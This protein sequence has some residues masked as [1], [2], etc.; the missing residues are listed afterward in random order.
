M[1]QIHRTGFILLG[2]RGGA[3]GF[4]RTFRRLL[5]Y[6]RP[7]WWR[8]RGRF[9]ISLKFLGFRVEGLWGVLG[10][11]GF[12]GVRVLLFRMPGFGIQ[13]MA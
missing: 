11:L 7:P 3:S 5:A 9:R 12:R 6:L 4:P 1:L 2:S 10:V 8:G 13:I